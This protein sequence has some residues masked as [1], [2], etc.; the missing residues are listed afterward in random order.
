MSSY[1]L[2]QMID[3]YLQKYGFPRDYEFGHS[4]IYKDYKNMQYIWESK[5]ETND[6]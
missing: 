6:L 4:M 5:H 3:N 1:I 2:I